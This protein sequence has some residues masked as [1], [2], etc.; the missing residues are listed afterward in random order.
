MDSFSCFDNRPRCSGGAGAGPPASRRGKLAEGLVSIFGLVIYRSLF[1]RPQE[2]AAI[3]KRG[4]KWEIFH[5][6]PLFLDSLFPGRKGSRP[7]GQPYR[8]E[9][10]LPP[11][12]PI[13]FSPQSR[14]SEKSPGG[15]AFLS[16]RESRVMNCSSQCFR[17]HWRRAR[18]R[19][20][21]SPC[22]GRFPSRPEPRL[23]PC[24]W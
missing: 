1:P 11:P 13:G 9:A 18:R 5:F 16:R 20:S 24:R 21:I 6:R 4:R 8:G 19:R 10:L 22:G 23:G 14:E 7:G 2:N 15:K 12:A 17:S 3:E